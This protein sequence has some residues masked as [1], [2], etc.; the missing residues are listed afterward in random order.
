MSK[1]KFNNR[2]GP[3]YRLSAV[4]TPRRKGVKRLCSLD[5]HSLK[6]EYASCLAWP[7]GLTGP[8]IKVHCNMQRLKV[9]DH[10]QQI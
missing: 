7:W 5:A 4:A 1:D 3:L 6:L 2:S 8:R 9:M 10:L